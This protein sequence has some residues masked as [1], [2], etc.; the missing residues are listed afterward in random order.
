MPTL[1]AGNI[2]YFNIYKADAILVKE[3]EGF[4]Q[5]FVCQWKVL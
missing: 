2:E 1:I 5:A 3:S 4:E